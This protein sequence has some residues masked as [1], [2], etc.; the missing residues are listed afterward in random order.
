[1]QRYGISYG[2]NCYF[3]ALR[4]EEMF[5]YFAH[6]VLRT[7]R[8]NKTGYKVEGIPVQ[9]TPVPTSF[10]SAGLLLS[11]GDRARTAVLSWS[12]GG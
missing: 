3:A 11:L 4:G 12:H 7:D 10:L 6:N 5:A 9:P 8:I 1:M 2:S